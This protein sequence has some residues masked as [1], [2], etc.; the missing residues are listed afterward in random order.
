ML[1]PGLERLD[2]P[3]ED[4]GERPRDD[5]PRL[6]RVSGLAQ[7]P[8]ELDDPRDEILEAAVDELAMALEHERIDLVA[9]RP[10]LLAEDE[11]VLHRA[12]VEVEAEPREA[13]LGRCRAAPA[14]RLRSAAAAARARAAATG[15]WRRC[16]GRRRARR[17]A[18]P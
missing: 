10:G 16:P 13:G 2:L 1:G 4:L 7:L 12:V 15:T 18:R 8:V 17:D 3:V 9:Q 14:R 11:H 6:E 5:A